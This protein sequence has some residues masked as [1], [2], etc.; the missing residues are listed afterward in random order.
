MELI[1]TVYPKFAQ[2]LATRY[3]MEDCLDFV[4][5]WSV[6]SLQCK[7]FLKKTKVVYK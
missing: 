5:P 3:N 2:D 7:I 6:Q 1:R 4:Y